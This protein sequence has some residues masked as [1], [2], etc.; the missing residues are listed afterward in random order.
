M[1]GKRH[2]TEALRR[3]SDE[4][5]R[6]GL[7][8]TFKIHRIPFF[9]EPGYE[10]KDASFQETNVQRKVRM[11]GS[12]EQWQKVAKQHRLAER[13]AE[14]GIVFDPERLVSSTLNSH[15][16]IQWVAQHQSTA[17]AEALYDVLNQ[18][19]HVQGLSLNDMDL[20]VQCAGEVG[21]CESATRN[22]LQSDRGRTEVLAMFE[23]VQQQQ[24]NSIP[25]FIVDG[26]H[27]IQGAAHVDEIE[28]LLR[29]LERSVADK[30]DQEEGSGAAAL[31]GRTVFAAPCG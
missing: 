27:L 1:I 26:Q 16:L 24:I 11:F 4:P 29:S 19:H 2:L 17:T 3:M 6:P 25:T 9:L 8:L 23:M 15:R 5:L 10:S 7:P 18:R 13:G 20:L 14:V 12:M 21:L 28:R 30:E 31:N 22:F